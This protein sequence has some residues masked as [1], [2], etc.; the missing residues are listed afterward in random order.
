VT[1]VFQYVDDY[2]LSVANLPFFK[3][4]VPFYRWPTLSYVTTLSIRNHVT[5]PSRDGLP[6]YGVRT[7]FAGDQRIY[8]PPTLLL[9]VAYHVNVTCPSEGYLPFYR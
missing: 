1:V 8:R 6:F 9:H 5:L 2:T 7:P 4:D 3:R